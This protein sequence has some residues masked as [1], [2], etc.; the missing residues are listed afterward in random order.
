MKSLQL[1]SVLHIISQSTS[2]F[3]ASL[4]DHNVCIYD[5]FYFLRPT[6]LP[7]CTLAP[8]PS[9]E[10]PPELLTF[11]EWKQAQLAS[12][13]PQRPSGDLNN[14]SHTPKSGQED[15]AVAERTNV[16]NSEGSP[17]DESTSLTQSTA[18]TRFRV[19]LTDRFNYASQDCTA[20]IQSAHKGA[21][22][23]SAILSGKKDRYMLSPCASK[24]KFV[25]VELCDDVRIDTVQLANYEFF[26]GVFKDI[27]IRLA[28]TLPANEQ[29]WI[30]AGVY[31]AKNV[32][33]VQSFHPPEGRQK[34][35]R[36]VRVEFMSHYGSE[37]YC[38]ISLLRVYGLTHMEDYRWDDWQI[39]NEVSPE[40]G[41]SEDIR[42]ASS[43]PSN[44]THA[45]SQNGSTSSDPV[46]VDSVDSTPTPIASD[47][48]ASVPPTTISPVIAAPQD[49]Q[50]S[51][52]T[53]EA[54]PDEL[55]VSMEVRSLGSIEIS[56]RA[57]AT[58]TAESAPVDEAAPAD[59]IH[60]SE[61]TSTTQSPTT[62]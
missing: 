42:A 25:I 18:H 15:D 29:D 11:E 48:S 38:P 27:R 2:A 31:R 8:R 59:H 37:Y 1:L 55:G 28:E 20:R 57:S 54:M 9:T 21:K 51:V 50:A 53:L 47:S 49:A 45:S 32:R 58:P 26:S 35:Y 46:P 17:A 19:P 61:A 7:T 52:S 5:T 41:N 23:P 4:N 39:A 40:S 6:P 62:A 3:S 56:T 33:G 14:V 10:A 44:D 36:Y 24:D 60:T 12:E 43:A 34:F 16:V 22:S 13:S 30:N